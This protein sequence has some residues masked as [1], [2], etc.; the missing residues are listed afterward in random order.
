MREKFSSILC[1]RQRILLIIHFYIG[2]NKNLKRKG[3]FVLSL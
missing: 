1:V 2:K 3:K